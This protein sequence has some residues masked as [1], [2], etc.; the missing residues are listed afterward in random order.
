MFPAGN[1]ERSASAKRVTKPAIR[2]RSLGLRIERSESPVAAPTLRRKLTN[3]GRDKPQSKHHP[4]AHRHTERMRRPNRAA[5][6]GPDNRLVGQSY[7]L[8]PD[9][10]VSAVPVRICR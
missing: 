6:P 9:R 7:C 2:K 5:V 3:P 4:G 8:S 1:R 10:F